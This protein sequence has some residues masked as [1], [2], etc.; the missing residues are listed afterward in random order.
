M[1]YFVKYKIVDGRKTTTPEGIMD[2]NTD[3]EL[4]AGDI[5]TKMK[6][7]FNFPPTK[8]IGTEELKLN[9]KVLEDSEVIPNKKSGLYYFVNFSVPTESVATPT[10]G[11]TV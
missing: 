7:W 6:E 9:N 5:K 2:I 10:S 3:V 4:T 11:E 1:K 8:S